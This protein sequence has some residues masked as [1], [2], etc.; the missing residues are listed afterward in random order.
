MKQ[1][2]NLLNKSLIYFY[3]IE[4]TYRPNTSKT[5]SCGR[6]SLIALQ[7]LL[8]IYGCIE[9]YYGIVYTYFIPRSSDLGRRNSQ[10]TLYFKKL[11]KYCNHNQNKIPI[12]PVT[13]G[14]ILH[15]INSMHIFHK[16]LFSQ[17]KF[18]I[19][20]NQQNKLLMEFERQP[21]TGFT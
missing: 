12:L 14:K 3:K 18:Y 9:Y 10:N 16:F 20:L 17:N 7:S 2:T 15:F 21:L 1:R 13:L 11:K 6:L 5:S 4:K 19:S 8:W